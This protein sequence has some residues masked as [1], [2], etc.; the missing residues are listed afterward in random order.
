MKKKNIG[1]IGCG[2]WAKIILPTLSKYFNI[3]FIINSKVNYKI[4]NLNNIDWIFILTNN[5]SHLKIVKYFLNKKKNV[6]C[7]KP[8][9]TSYKNT[10]ELFNLAKNKKTKLYVDDVEC[11]KNKHLKINKVNIIKR[12]K[13]AKKSSESLLF[14][15]A[16]H[17]FYLLKNYIDLKKI[18]NIKIFENSYNLKIYFTDYNNKKFNFLYKTNSNLNVHKIN[19]INLLEYKKKPLDIMFK[20]MIKNSLNYKANQARSVFSNKLISILKKKY[21]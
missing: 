12:F 6:F 19:S 4:F 11:F 15:L 21:K 10:L 3:N 9:T 20:K 5:T 8:L 18:N 2:K 1:I 16:Y 17:D 14:R 13:K 7:E